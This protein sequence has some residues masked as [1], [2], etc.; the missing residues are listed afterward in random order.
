MNNPE[1][2]GRV[3]LATA[4]RAARDILG[5]DEEAA[6]HLVASAA[7]QVLV[8]QGEGTQTIRIVMTNERRAALVA[9]QL[10]SGLDEA[11]FFDVVTD[12]DRIAEALGFEIEQEPL[13]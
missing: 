3:A 10:Q 12:P 8:T 11:S 7:A 5:G 13:Q 4:L 9:V 2:N 6:L 1:T